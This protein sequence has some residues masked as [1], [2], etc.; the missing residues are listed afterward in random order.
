MRKLSQIEKLN[1]LIASKD[2]QF[3]FEKKELIDEINGFTESLRPINLIKNKIKSALSDAAPFS[4]M[5]NGALGYFGGLLAKKIFVGKSDSSLREI[6]GAL[7][8]MLVSSKVSA[9]AE[10]L[11]ALALSIF[12]RFSKN[13]EAE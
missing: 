6:E 12:H 5:M 1:E 7:L 2:L 8:Q 3:Q 11:K 9:N 4:G 13:K 10:D